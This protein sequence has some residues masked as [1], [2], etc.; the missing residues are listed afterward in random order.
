MVQ[1]NFNKISTFEKISPRCSKKDKP[2]GV[3]QLELDGKAIHVYESVPDTKR[4]KH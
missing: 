1:M 4:N 2:Q 3:K